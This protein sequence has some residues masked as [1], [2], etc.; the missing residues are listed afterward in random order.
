WLDESRTF[1]KTLP[2]LIREY[3]DQ[4]NEYH[5]DANAPEVRSKA[6]E[7]GVQLKAMVDPL[8][9]YQGQLP[10]FPEIYRIE[11]R[12]LDRPSSV[13]PISWD[14]PVPRP[15]EQF[16]SHIRSLDRVVT[17]SDGKPGAVVR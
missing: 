10:A 4:L 12:F 2:E 5:D 7:I 16:R 9:L 8:R 1:R 13:L 14:S 17:G 6:Q 3:L 11:V 15:R